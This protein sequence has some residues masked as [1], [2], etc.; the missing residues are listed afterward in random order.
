M[1]PRERTKCTRI[2]VEHDA[3]RYRSCTLPDYEPRTGKRPF[4]APLA[5]DAIAEKAL[6]F[7]HAAPEMARAI[8]TIWH[9]WGL[10][11][12]AAVT[13]STEPSPEKPPSLP[14]CAFVLPKRQPQA[15][16]VRGLPY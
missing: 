7:A 15:N 9:E 13:L 12:S 3:F 11:D 8:G 6:Q 16:G 10:I 4:C 2:D 14:P 1:S 5:A